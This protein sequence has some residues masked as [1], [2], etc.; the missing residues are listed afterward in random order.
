MTFRHIVS[1]VPLLLHL[2]HPAL[3]GYVEDAPAG[4]A[5]FTLSNYQQNFLSKEHPEL[6]EAVQSAV[7]SDAVFAQIL[8][9][10]VMGSFGSISQTSA[11][12]LDIWICHQDDLSEQ[13]QQRLA[14]KTKKISQWASTFHVEMHFYLMTQKRFRNE[15]YSDPLTKENSGS[16]QYM[17]FIGRVLSFRCT[18]CG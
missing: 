7:N 4:I 14:E 6:V 16:A 15:R 13:E 9:I 8:G 1:L 5:D 18:P 10:Y 3:P 2:N 17:L 11:S 12:D